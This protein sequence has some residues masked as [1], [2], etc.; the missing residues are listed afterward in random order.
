MVQATLETQLQRKGFELV[1]LRGVPGVP[2]EA[3]PGAWLFTACLTSLY[4]LSGACSSLYQGQSNALKLANY[5]N[6]MKGT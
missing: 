6:L 1:G 2:C 5:L 4:C 3:C